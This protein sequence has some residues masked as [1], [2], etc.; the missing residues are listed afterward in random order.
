MSYI[1]KIINDINNKI[2]VGKTD[3]SIEKRFQEHCRD[4]QKNFNEKRPL[5][6]A[7]RKYGVEHFHIELVEETDYPEEREIYWIEQLDTYNNRYNATKG[8]EGKSLYNHNLILNKLKE[9]PYLCDIAEE[10]GCS[11]DLIYTLAK[12]N[13]ISIKRKVN[14]NPC[15]NEPKQIEAWTKSGKFVKKFFSLRS[16]IEWCYEIGK[17]KKISSGAIGHIAEVAN[18]KR[19]SAFGYVWKYINKEVNSND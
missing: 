9:H 14:L 12:D 8:G 5:Y 15:I 1:Y 13:N 6:S 10:I 7:M 16:A 2:Y 4:C 11:R 18:K 19:K 17:C 3:F